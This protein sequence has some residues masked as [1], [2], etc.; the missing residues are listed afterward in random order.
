MSKALHFILFAVMCG[1]FT[2]CIER[3][4]PSEDDLKTGTLVINAHLTNQPGHQVIEISRSVTLIYPSSDPVLGSF[5]EVIREDGEF[6]E[7]LE[8]RPGYYGCNLDETFL[9]TGMSYMVHVITPDGNEYESGF[10][11]LRPVP[12]I[13][14]I[15]Y[16]VES[17]SYQIE[18]D[19][20]DGIRFYIDFTYNDEDY[21][22]IRWDVTETYEFHNP[23]MEAFIW[24][25]DRRVKPLPDTS[26][27]RVCYI[28]KQLFEI[29]SMALGYLDFGIYIRKPFAFV[30]NIQQEQKLK[31]KYSVL[32]KQYSMGEEAFHY[33]NELKKTSQEQGFLFDRQPA[34]LKSNIRNVN[35]EDEIVLGFFSMAGVTGARAFAE[36]PEGIDLSLYEWYCFPVVKGPSGPVSREDL[37]KYYARAWRDGT[38]VYAEVNKHCVDCR[39]YKNSTHIPPDFW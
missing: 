26:N 12:E 22:Y 19:S 16:E 27:Y 28:T 17:A 36:K 37:P 8:E 23:D 39:A 33:W 34:L 10:D 24:D 30:P 14:S 25:V 32:I 20:T 1:L 11:K 5:A 13:D 6:R 4:Y 35:N 18:S 31:H 9:H 38:S 3:Y 7:F 2:G 29:H 15:Y 21:D